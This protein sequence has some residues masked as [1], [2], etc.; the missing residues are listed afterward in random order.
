MKETMEKTMALNVKKAFHES[1]E[2]LTQ[3][4]KQVVG[5]ALVAHINAVTG[6]RHVLF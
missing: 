5:G 3:S 2:L 4:F 6:I 1:I